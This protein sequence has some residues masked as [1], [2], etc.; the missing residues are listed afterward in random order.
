M[1]KAGVA[2][3]AGTAREAPNLT[4]RERVSVGRASTIESMAKA[5]V[6]IAAGIAA[7]AAFFMSK[8]DST[9]LWTTWG[10]LLGAKAN[11]QATRAKRVTSW[12]V[13]MVGWRVGS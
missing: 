2:I 5:G 6:A 1:A 4:S 3:T 7:M 10:A 8:P 9:T 12:K 11:E 13:F